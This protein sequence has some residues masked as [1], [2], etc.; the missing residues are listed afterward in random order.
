MFSSV[1]SGPEFGTLTPKDIL[2]MMGSYSFCHPST[3]SGWTVK[4]RDF[5]E[6]PKRSWWASR[7]M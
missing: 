1:D 4:Y 6:T 7:T 3:G 5:T 2:F